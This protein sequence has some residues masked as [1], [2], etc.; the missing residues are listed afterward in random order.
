[1]SRHLRINS[2][3]E[4]IAREHDDAA[5]WLAEHDAERIAAEREARR[6]EARRQVVGDLGCG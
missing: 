5:L 6:S 3:A 2:R 4:R 1:M